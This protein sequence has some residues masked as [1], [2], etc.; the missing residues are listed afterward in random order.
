MAQ[1]SPEDQKLLDDI[2][3]TPQNAVASPAPTTGPYWDTVHEQIK[4][5]DDS[6]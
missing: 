4:S 3:G 1:I 2:Y 6:K 5:F